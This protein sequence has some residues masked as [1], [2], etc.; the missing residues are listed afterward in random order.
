MAGAGRGRVCRNGPGCHL[1]CRFIR[2]QRTAMVGPTPLIIVRR[3]R[4]LEFIIVQMALSAL[5]APV[6]V[7]VADGRIGVVNGNTVNGA[8]DHRGMLRAMG[9]VAIKARENKI[10]GPGIWGSRVNCPGGN[11]HTVLIPGGLRI[12][13]CSGSRPVDGLQRHTSVLADNRRWSAG[14]VAIKAKGIVIGTGGTVGDGNTTRLINGCA[15]VIIRRK[16]CAGMVGHI[17]P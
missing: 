17:F 16:I 8:P 10:A 7:I 5:P 9:L 2:I 3:C 13:R 4:R 15:V 14:T 6:T 11:I 1:G 12:P